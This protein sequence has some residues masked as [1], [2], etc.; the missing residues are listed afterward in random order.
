MFEKSDVDLSIMEQKIKASM[1]GLYKMKVR[2]EPYLV[3][4]HVVAEELSITGEE[5]EVKDAKIKFLDEL[6]EQLESP[7]EKTETINNLEGCSADPKP[8]LFRLQ[9]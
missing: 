5:G 1:H 4:A 8:I 7:L 3:K 2:D 6:H 9:T